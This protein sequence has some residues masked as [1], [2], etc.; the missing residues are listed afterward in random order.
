[1][2]KGGLRK[3]AAKL[4]GGGRRQRQEEAILPTHVRAIENTDA[5]WTNYLHGLCGQFKLYNLVAGAT[6]RYDEE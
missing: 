2:P 6:L 1:M 4:H 3:R 5:A